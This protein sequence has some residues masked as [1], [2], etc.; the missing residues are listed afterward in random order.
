VAGIQCLAESLQLE[1]GRKEHKEDLRVHPLGSRAHAAGRR[2]E[3]TGMPAALIER[4]IRLNV[5]R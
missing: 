4:L 1:L 5:E 2:R 3:V